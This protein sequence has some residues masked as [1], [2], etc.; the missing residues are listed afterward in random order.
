MWRIIV[1][2]D[3]PQMTVW[4]MRI[5]CW[6]PQATETHSEY[7]ILSAFFHRNNGCTNAPPCYTIRTLP[8]LFSEWTSNVVVLVQQFL[9]FKCFILNITAVLA[10][11]RA[12][13][14]HFVYVC[15]CMH[16]NTKLQCTAVQVCSVSNRYSRKLDSAHSFT[17]RPKCV[18]LMACC[19]FHSLCGICCTVW[20]TLHEALWINE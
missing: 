13:L 14:L 10:W 19:K 2:R 1:E 11:C 9:K 8:V 5:A 15:E 17:R 12:V 6:I 16:T 3:R 20:M 7:V 18:K 4:R